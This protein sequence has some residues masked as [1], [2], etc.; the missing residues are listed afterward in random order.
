MDKPTRGID[1]GA[2]RD[3]YLLIGELVKQGKAVIVISS[4]IPEV[5]GLSDRI[6]VMAKDG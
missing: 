3:I 1:A 5:M 2:K 4:E 6:L